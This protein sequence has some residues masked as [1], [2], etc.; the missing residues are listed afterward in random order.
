MLARRG[1]ISSSSSLPR[2]TNNT[3]V[4]NRCAAT[5]AWP[6]LAH[7]P[8]QRGALRCHRYRSSTNRRKRP[9]IHTN[10]AVERLETSVHVADGVRAESRFRSIFGSSCTVSRD[11]DKLPLIAIRSHMRCCKAKPKPSHA[12]LAKGITRIQGGFYLSIPGTSYHM[13]LERRCKRPQPYS[14]V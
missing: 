5:A 9:L 6:G 4:S 8:G 13:Y 11:T 14:I 3:S 1:G 12:F 10:M 2:A 7:G